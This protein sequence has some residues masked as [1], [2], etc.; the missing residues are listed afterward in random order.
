M[1]DYLVDDENLIG[2]KGADDGPED[3]DRGAE[4]SDVDFENAE[5]VHNGSVVGHI[6]DGNGASA[7]DA[8]GDHAAYRNYSDA[9]IALAKA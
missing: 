8:E 7:V 2:R 1:Y 4:N 5:D 9:G 3:G 6:Q